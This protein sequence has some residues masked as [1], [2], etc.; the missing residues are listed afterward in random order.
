MADILKAKNAIATLR[1]AEI[2]LRGARELESIGVLAA[3]HELIAGFEWLEESRAG[4]KRER[5]QLFADKEEWQIR[6]QA[7]E[8][9]YRA[10]AAEIEE[11]NQV[12][13]E[14]DR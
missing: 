2:G 3:I 1:T 12:S 7:F 8:Q 10:A 5:D 9:K 6:A 11:R 14:R 13:M 4:L